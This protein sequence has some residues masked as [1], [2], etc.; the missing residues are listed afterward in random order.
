MTRRSTSNLMK[1]PCFRGKIQRASINYRG[2]KLLKKLRKNSLIPKT[3]DQV[4][5]SDIQ[6]IAHE[7]RDLFISSNE[8]PIKFVFVDSFFG[9]KDKA[10]E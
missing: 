10:R 1:I 7:I 8:E 9:C 5:N 4:S 3:F 6:R 2:A